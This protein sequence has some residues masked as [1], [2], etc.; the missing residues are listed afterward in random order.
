M[1]APFSSP[2]CS[3]SFQVHRGKLFGILGPNGAGKATTINMLIGLARPDAGSIRIVG[4]DC[5][6]NP[7]AAQHLIG[8]VPDEN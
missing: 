5:R 4:H 3:I 8:L 2:Q 1:N 7:K 6:K